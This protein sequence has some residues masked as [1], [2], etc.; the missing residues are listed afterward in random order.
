MNVKIHGNIVLANDSCVEISHLSTNNTIF[1]VDLVNLLADSYVYS[2]NETTVVTSKKYFEHVSVD[3]LVI[4]SYLIQQD[5]STEDILVNLRNLNKGIQLKG[6]ITFATE[7][8]INNLTVADAINEIPSA[9]FGHNWL[10]SEG[11]Q[12]W[13]HS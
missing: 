9:Q 8:H 2:P 5:Q 11:K 7:F 10:L 4:E 12:V 3:Q 13:K 1:G 6:P